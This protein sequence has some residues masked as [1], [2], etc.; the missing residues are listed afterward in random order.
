MRNLVSASWLQEHIND[1]NIVI[2]DC[3]FD[4]Y[5]P[6]Y[7]K[8]TF[9][10]G[11][12]KNAIF[13]NLDKDL[14]GIPANHG[15]A[16]P[17]PDLDQLLSV[18]SKAGI[19]KDTTIIG[20][21]DQLNASARLW[22][23]LKYI[24]HKSCYLLDGGFKNWVKQGYPL[25]T[26]VTSPDILKVSKDIDIHL[27]KEIF[28]EIEYVKHKKDIPGVTLI[29]SRENE[30]FTGK[31]ENLYKKAG[32]I[33]GAVNFPCKKIF[34]GEGFLKKRKK[35]SELWSWLEPDQ[36]IILYCGSGIAASVNFLALDEL[37]YFPKLY[38]G[39][40]SDW[41]SYKNNQVEK[42]NNPPTQILN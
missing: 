8:K 5:N 23:T 21:D 28:C 34:E 22:W 16:R 13:L 14:V 42:N 20:Y 31:R 15:G 9:H 4:L 40:F 6:E 7:G 3:R 10:L 19:N 37:G 30:R 36:E 12:L 39:G 29:D 18:L 41:I 27:N 24:G 11:H 33:P 1:R 35:L 2:I 26:E 25:T 32:H 17:L 38:V